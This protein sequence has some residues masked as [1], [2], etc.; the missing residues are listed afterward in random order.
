MGLLGFLGL[1]DWII[2]LTTALV[3]L[4]MYVTRNTD[5][6][7]KQNVVHIPFFQC[8]RVMLKVLRMPVPQLDM[9]N[10]EDY[11]RVFGKFVLMTTFWTT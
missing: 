4:Y 8:I 1:P 6:W 2:L 9:E 11:G 7:K 10:L 5:Y 3:L